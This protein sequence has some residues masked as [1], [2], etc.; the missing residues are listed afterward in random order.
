MDLGIQG[1][2]FW[3]QSPTKHVHVQH[4]ASPPTC[5]PLEAA[6]R[7]KHLES[8]FLGWHSFLSTHGFS[9]GTISRL[10]LH[11]ASPM[12]SLPSLG[13]HRNSL[14]Q[15]GIDMWD[16]LSPS[17]RHARI[18]LGDT[19]PPQTHR[20]PTVLRILIGSHRRQTHRCEKS[21]QFSDQV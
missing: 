5:K 14:P 2:W 1:R 10:G 19:H 13:G 8:L 9:E 11:S 6:Q 3:N 7:Q 16:S 12:D 21:Y 15:F 18:R 4:T 20:D 17:P